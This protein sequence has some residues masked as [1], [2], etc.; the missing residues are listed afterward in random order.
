MM[1][2]IKNPSEEKQDLQKDLLR[3]KAQ[4]YQ[5]IFLILGIRIQ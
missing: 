4:L 1:G 5:V 3:R 2:H